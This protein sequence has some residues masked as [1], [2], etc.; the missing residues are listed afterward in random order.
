[1]KTLDKCTICRRAGEKLF[2]K[3]EKCN[4]PKCPFVKRSYAPGDAGSKGSLK[5]L[6]DFGIQLKEKQ[7]A[8]AVYG[9]SERQ[10][11]NYVKNNPGENL[12]DILESRID[13]VIHK[14]GISESRR[15]ARQLISHGKI[16]LNGKKI[17]SSSVPT[18]NGDIISLHNLKV[19]IRKSAL[20]AYVKQTSDNSFELVDQ[21]S[22]VIK[23]DLNKIN[24]QLIIEY[25]SR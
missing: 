23:S 19:E 12:I 9:L 18:K 8:R 3:G 22:I 4:S 20:P 13:S 11:E 24:D 2:L 17:K 15:Q 25:Y 5:K 16:M 6:S 21:P 10:M 7:K 1:M 14:I